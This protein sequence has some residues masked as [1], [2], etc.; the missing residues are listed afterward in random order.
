MTLMN[1]DQIITKVLAG[2]ASAEELASL[3]VWKQESQDNLAKLREMSDLHD[4]ADALDGYQ[5]FDTDAAW[6]TVSPQIDTP[7]PSSSRWWWLAAVLVLAAGIYYVTT[8]KAVPTGPTIHLATDDVLRVP[9][10]DGSVVHLDRGGRLEVPTDW[11][12]SRSVSLS[13]RAYFD[14]AKQPAGK[15]FDIQL[16]QGVVTV[17]G[18]AF[19]VDAT[20][21][22]VEV[23]VEEGHVVYSLDNRKVDLRADDRVQ[24]INGTLAKTSGLGSQYFSWMKN[25]L[26]FKDMLIAEA[27][28]KLSHHVNKQIAIAAG[29]DISNCRISGQY[30][31]TDVDEILK[32]WSLLLDL[33]YKQEGDTYLITSLACR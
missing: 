12:E 9:L 6:A 17:V 14:V 32:E 15:S 16:D 29:V 22:N 13:G 26:V 19:A 1:I 25:S 3:N 10:A 24:L 23:G 21:G 2:S 4:A 27:L 30:I 5:T 20:V 8:Q 11:D 33:T 28:P 7:Q 31:T 18:T